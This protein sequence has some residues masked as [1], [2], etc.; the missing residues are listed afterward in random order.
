MRASRRP[1]PAAARARRRLSWK[2]SGARELDS[3]RTDGRHDMDRR[4]L[5]KGLAALPILSALPASA[6]S[7]WPARNITMVVPFPPGGQADLAARPVA[8]A[9][10]KIL[11]KSVVVD[12]RAGGAGGSVGIVAAARA[13]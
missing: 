6:Q 2:P 10:E 9:L 4:Q 1:A 3:R 7:D 12:N 8:A 11:G 13:E 5:L